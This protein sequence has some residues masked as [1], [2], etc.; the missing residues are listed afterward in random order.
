MNQEIV[1]FHIEK[2]AMVYAY[3]QLVKIDVVK[4]IMIEYMFQLVMWKIGIY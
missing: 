3:K 2:D 1:V 4:P